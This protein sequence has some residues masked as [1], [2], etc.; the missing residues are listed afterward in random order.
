M[1]SEVTPNEILTAAIRNMYKIYCQLNLIPPMKT[2]LQEATRDLV[3]A[4]INLFMDDPGMKKI[5]IEF[6]ILVIENSCRYNGMGYA[7]TFRKELYGWILEVEN[8]YKYNSKLNEN[9]DKPCDCNP[10]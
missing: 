8:E 3:K 7:D 6:V 2:D 4:Y 5:A 9:T 10:S 1:K